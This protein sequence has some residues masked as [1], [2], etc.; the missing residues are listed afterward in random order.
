MVQP[1]AQRNK[2]SAP[3]KRVDIREGVPVKLVW[4]YVVRGVTSH[5]RLRYLK[6]PTDASAASTEAHEAG[7]DSSQTKKPITPHKAAPTIRG[8]T[9][10]AIGLKPAPQCAAGW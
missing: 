1:P 4:L 9:A 3:P 2:N 5:C 10:K 8:E 6:E 7:G